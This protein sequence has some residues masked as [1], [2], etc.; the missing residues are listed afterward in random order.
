MPRMTAWL[1]ALLMVPTMAAC[2]RSP[3]RPPRPL[4][5]P[6]AARMPAGLPSATVAAPTAAA[7]RL[8][9]TLVPVQARTFAGAPV[10][11]AEKGASRPTA[12]GDSQDYL[13]ILQN[14]DRVQLSVDVRTGSLRGFY[15]LGQ[16]AATVKRDLEAARAAA[17]AFATQN[18]PQF[19]AAAMQQVRAELI[20]SSDSSPK[21]YLFHWTQID[22]ISKAVLPNEIRIHV[23]AETGQVDSYSALKVEVTV[24]TQPIIDESQARQLA[25][26]TFTNA[27]GMRVTGS[28]LFVSTLPV[29]QPN[30]RQALLWAVVLEGEADAIGYRQRAHVFVDAAT[31]EV[32]DAEP[33]S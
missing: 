31:G 4:P 17:L 25:L 8:E 13:A 16:Q 2:G 22:P 23:N 30:G 3:Q 6:I 20:D 21:Y 1:V 9:P 28:A 7:D 12:F 11:L 26:S 14:G 19:E 18:Y 24:P 5:T 33:G 15:R 10:K 29:G 27:G 32:F